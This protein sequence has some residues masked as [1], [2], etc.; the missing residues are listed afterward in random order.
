MK[1]LFAVSLGALLGLNAVAETG[2]T[3]AEGPLLTRWA[4]EIAP[5]Q[6]LPE[7]PRPQLRR[8]EW[9][10]LNGFWDY[11]IGPRTEPRPK[12]ADGQILVPYPLESALSGVGESITANDLLWYTR[13]F[14]LPEAWDGQRVMLN[15]G[16]VDWEA[17]VWVNGRFVGEHRGGYTPFAFDITSALAPA[18]PQEITVS[19]WDPTDEG[20]QPRGKQVRE[21]GEIWYTAVTGIW[22]TVWI[23]PVPDQHVSALRVTPDVNRN[24]VRIETSLASKAPATV[25]A[26]VYDNGRQIGEA[27]GGAVE[28]PIEDPKLWSPESPFLYD[29]TVTVEAADG[30][31]TDVVE[32]YFGMR[33]VRLGKDGNGVQRILL[34]GEFVFQY[35]LLDQGWWPDGLYTAPTD[36]ALRYDVEMTKAMGFNM[37]RK[38]VKVEPARWYYWADK[39]GLLVWQDMPNGDEHIGRDDPDI[40]RAAQSARQ[41][42]REYL[43][44]IGALYNHPSIVMWIPFNEGWGQFDT[45]RIVELTRKH[46]PTRLVNNASGWTDRGVGDVHDIHRYPGPAAPEAEEDRAIV[47]GEFGGLGL[48]VEGHLWQFDDAWGYRSY[49]SEEELLDAYRNLVKELRPLI[50]EPGLSAAVY[51][52]TTDVE[53]EV[54]G[55]MTYDRAVTKIDPGVLTEINGVLYE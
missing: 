12:Q 39:L 7:Y 8:P 55:L 38:H 22:Q 6:P 2:W 31:T 10:S 40:E 49:D 32:S 46:D 37:A 13:P 51:T 4:E 27:T 15:F 3:P 24:A 34:N 5:E 42:E 17:R 47:L 36:D 48:I 30:A 23:E 9:K 50:D 45:E 1:A 52:Q 18:G 28:I 14:E 33:D 20:Y 43:A 19:V 29:L 44:M 25:T 11:A 41:F 54:N 35:G 26:R 16:A 21:P 53:I